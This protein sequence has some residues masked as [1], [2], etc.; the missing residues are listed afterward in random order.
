MGV[1][2][3]RD[4]GL[5]R[6]CCEYKLAILGSKILESKLEEYFHAHGKGLH[7]KVSSIETILPKDLI[8]RL[9]RIA[10]IRN[11]IVH[12]VEFDHSGFDGKG[13]RKDFVHA[14]HEL[15]QLHK[16]RNREHSSG[17]CIIS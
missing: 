8:R 3:S 11:Q 5:G 16:H 4:D 10:T 13:Y 17:M 2:F 9:R 7:E 12:S 6:P 1:N 14:Q 15:D